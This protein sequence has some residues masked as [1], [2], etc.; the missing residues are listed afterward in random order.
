VTA[1]RG[2]TQAPYRAGRILRND[3]E[4]EAVRFYKSEGAAFSGWIVRSIHD[5]YSV[6]DPIPTKAEAIEQLLGWDL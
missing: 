6:S 3:G 1:P 2:Y 4:V 5:Q